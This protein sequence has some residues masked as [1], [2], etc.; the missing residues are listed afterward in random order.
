MS[1]N[2]KS[3]GDASS[4][5]GTIDNSTPPVAEVVPTEDEVVNPEAEQGPEQAHR[6]EAENELRQKI[7]DTKEKIKNFKGE[8][9]KP[10]RD[11]LSADLSDVETYF[12]GEEDSV[13]QEFTEHIA[14][15]AEVLNRLSK[16]VEKTAEKIA[17]AEA[18]IE[19]DRKEKIRVIDSAMSRLEHISSLSEDEAVKNKN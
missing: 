17:A 8:K 13:S 1:P 7:E 18:V 2:I 3:S 4:A 10:I 5:S 6:D 12:Q 15:L 16:V 14:D 19:K 11:K 9:L